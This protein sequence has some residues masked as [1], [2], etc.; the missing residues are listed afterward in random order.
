MVE[1]PQFYDY[2]LR[3]GRSEEFICLLETVNRQ[4]KSL[5]L[6]TIYDPINKLWEKLPPIPAEFEFCS[7][8]KLICVKH[9]LVLLGLSQRNRAGS[10]RKR[11]ETTN[12][13][14]VFD[15]LSCK[16]RKGADMP[17]PECPANF[18]CCASPEGLIYL[19]GGRQNGEITGKATSQAAAL[20][21]YDEE[22]QQF[23]PETEVWSIL[24]NMW[25]IEDCLYPMV[26]AFG[27][28]YCFQWHVVTEYD[29]KEN[30]WRIV[31]GI[32]EPLDS[33]DAAVLGDRIFLSGVESGSKNHTFFYIYQPPL[34][35]GVNREMDLC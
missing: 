8:S 11:T 2:R 17:T 33:V 25:F 34:K 7:S 21:M 12:A 15:F 32:P 14:L 5:P 9:K 13:I 29:C 30:L 10:K 35:T 1:D 20:S 6:V 4:F 28:L 3:C 24:P 22:V 16:W 23:E 19:A 27:R 26:A 31:D 18:G